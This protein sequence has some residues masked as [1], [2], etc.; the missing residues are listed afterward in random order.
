[1][2]IGRMLRSNGGIQLWGHAMQ[3]A[4]GSQPFSSQRAR[5][6][7]GAAM[8]CGLIGGALMAFLLVSLS[9]CVYGEPVW[10]LPRMLAALALGPD[11]LQPAGTFNAVIV[12]TALAVLGTFSIV[13]GI[14]FAGLAQLREAS[15][16]WLGLAAGGA[17]YAG[18]L[19]GFTAAFPW[20]AEL[21]SVDTLAVH[22]VFGLLAAQA[23]ADR[24]A[25]AER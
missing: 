16:P 9:V 12:A 24:V 3:L 22:L 8:R 2:S 1:M 11:A 21:R 14:A 5:F 7:A 23:Y 20:L 15:A 19:Y 17:L 10:K 25:G 4:H 18:H 13:Y 6:D